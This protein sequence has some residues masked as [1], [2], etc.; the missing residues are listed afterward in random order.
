MNKQ[1]TEAAT[2]LLNLKCSRTNETIKANEIV[3]IHNWGMST[4]GQVLGYG[5]FEWDK[6]ER[7]FSFTPHKGM[8]I[9]HSLDEDSTVED[10]YDLF[11]TSP[12]KLDDLEKAELKSWN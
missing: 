9:A 3:K 1:E 2:L 8:N 5:H 10:N 12:A 7:K 6:Q 11:R 4:F